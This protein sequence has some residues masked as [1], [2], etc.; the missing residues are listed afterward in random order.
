MY[1]HIG[2]RRSDRLS[3]VHTSRRTFCKGWGLT[4]PQ[5]FSERVGVGDFSAIAVWWPECG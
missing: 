3:H 5:F 4:R 1:M 2:D